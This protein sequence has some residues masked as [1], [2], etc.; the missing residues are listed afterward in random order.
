MFLAPLSAG[1]F[2]YLFQWILPPDVVLTVSKVLWASAGSLSE[3]LLP[4]IGL[5]ICLR[6]AGGRYVLPVLLYWLSVATFDWGMYILKP[7]IQT[8]IFQFQGVEN[9]DWPFIMD[10]L[11]LQAYAEPIG[12]TLIFLAIVLFVLAVWSPFYYWRHMDQYPI[13]YCEFW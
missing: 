6:T 5:I 7:E 11:G 2:T 10:T 13:P 8:D 9:G 1:I 3:C 4:F 12:S